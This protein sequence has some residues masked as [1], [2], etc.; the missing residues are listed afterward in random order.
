LGEPAGPRGQMGEG[1]RERPDHGP[2]DT[3]VEQLVVDVPLLLIDGTDA[4]G[5]HRHHEIDVTGPGRG[6]RHYPAALAEPPQ[7]HAVL[8]DARRSAE[9]LPGGE[10]VIGE[11]AVVAL[12][13]RVARGALVVAQGRD[14]RAGVA[15]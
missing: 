4:V 2:L 9:H 6:A 8:V 10:S 12:G 1:L 5:R 7:S 15:L 14:P 13:P 3:M 11:P